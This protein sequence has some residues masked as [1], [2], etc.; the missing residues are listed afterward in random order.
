MGMVSNKIVYIYRTLTTLINKKITMNKWL[1][2]NLNIW[3]TIN[4]GR[5]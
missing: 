4:F 5:E 3:C 1:T 2:I